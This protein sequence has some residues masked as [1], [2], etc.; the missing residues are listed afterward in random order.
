MNRRDIYEYIKLV[1]RLQGGPVSHI[2]LVVTLN[3]E[4]VD[5]YGSILPIV[6]FANYAVKGD[7]K[8]V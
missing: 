6:P 8:A 2:L 3:F 7:S 4:S 1:R 5:D